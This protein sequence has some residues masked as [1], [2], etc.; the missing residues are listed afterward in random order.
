M[1]IAICDDDAACREQVIKSI[2]AYIS[3]NENKDISLSVFRDAEELLNEVFKNGD[4]DM[5]IL[6]VV[7]P[8]MNGIELGEELR[9]NGYDGKI[10]YLALSREYAVDSYRIKAF[11]YLLKPVKNDEM[12]PVL[13]AV[14]STADKS[15]KSIIVKTKE[16]SVKIRL[17]SI[18]Y[19]KLAR[20]NVIYYLTN[21]KTVESISIR[22]NFIDT[23]QE[24]LRDK[25]FVLCGAS[26]AVN[27]TYIT[28]V[29]NEAVV[30]C[31]NN[32]VYFGVK[33]CRETR[34]AWINFCVNEEENIW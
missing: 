17:D 12:F 7:M 32:K 18:M 19:V 23:I 26:A 21:G 13:D 11:N 16:S 9:N 8:G 25:R 1:K 31:E 15:D 34:S 10:V 4:F 24:I 22:T 2:K 33:A 6:D 5:Y 30:F 28:E 14:M 20:R 27:M 29:S 3:Q